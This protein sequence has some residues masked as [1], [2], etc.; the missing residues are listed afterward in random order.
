M[1]EKEIEKIFVTEISHM[2]GKA[3]KFISPGNGG[4][5]DRVVCLPGGETYFV[6]LKTD[7]GKLTPLQKV[8]LGK[9]EKMG[10]RVYVLHGLIEVAE[11]FRMIGRDDIAGRVRRKAE[12]G[13]KNAI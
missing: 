7:T 5:P 2:G 13:K 4:V 1:L 6:E 11:F 10:Q 9:L 8:Q 3:Y 12:R